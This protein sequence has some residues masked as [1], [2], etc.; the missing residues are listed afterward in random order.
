MTHHSLPTV[1]SWGYFLDAAVFFHFILLSLKCQTIFLHYVIF[2][3]QSLNI[4]PG[5]SCK[6]GVG[7]N[8]LFSFFHQFISL[9]HTLD[10]SACCLKFVFIYPLSLEHH[11][12]YPALDIVGFLL[13]YSNRANDYDNVIFLFDFEYSWLFWPSFSIPKCLQDDF[14]MHSTHKNNASQISH[15]TIF[16]FIALCS[17]L[18]L[19]I[20]DNLHLLV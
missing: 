10:N 19:S 13:S 11:V 4:Y 14:L 8:G 15:T 18:E 16:V 12:I 1:L 5:E 2:Q 17:C 6:K 20:A 3:K 9:I 7:L